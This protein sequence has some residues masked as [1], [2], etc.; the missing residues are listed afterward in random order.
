MALTGGAKQQ[1]A[2]GTRRRPP[3]V[4]EVGHRVSRCK[5]VVVRNLPTGNSGGLG[6]IVLVLAAR[7]CPSSGGQI[8]LLHAR[9]NF[10][11]FMTPKLGEQAHL[12]IA[13]DQCGRGTDDLDAFETRHFPV[14]LERSVTPIQP[15]KNT[16]EPHQRG[17]S[18]CA[19]GR[20]RQA[21]IR[22]GRLTQRVPLKLVGFRRRE[23]R[24]RWLGLRG[25]D[26]IEDEDGRRDRLNRLLVEEQHQSF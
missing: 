16:R 11:R 2:V 5:A 20:A 22:V 13:R 17:C 24:V 9:E 18:N 4:P 6:C 3:R 26:G 8:V 12:G 7:H 21:A 25:K 15:P 1:A 14:D 10:S 23:E 19:I